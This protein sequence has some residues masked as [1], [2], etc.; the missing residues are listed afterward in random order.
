V[1]AIHKLIV[2]LYDK[3]YRLVGEKEGL[4]AELYGQY[5]GWFSAACGEQSKSCHHTRHIGIA[6]YM[7]GD[8]STIAV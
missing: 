3:N 6:D 8:A 7:V 1:L 5:A 2:I 4:I